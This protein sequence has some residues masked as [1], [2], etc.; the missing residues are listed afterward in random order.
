LFKHF[1]TEFHANWQWFDLLTESRAVD[2]T[3]GFDAITPILQCI[4][5]PVRN[6]KMSF[7]FE[8]RVG[9]GRLLCCGLNLSQPDSPVTR[10]FKHSLNDY[11]Q[12]ADFNPQVELDVASL[13]GVLQSAP[14][15]WLSTHVKRIE[16]NSQWW[17]SP[18]GNCIDGESSTYWKSGRGQP[19]PHDIIIELDETRVIWGARYT[20]RQDGLSAGWVKDY[21][22]YISEEPSDWGEPTMSGRFADSAD[23]Q[24]MVP[25]LTDDGFNV[26]HSKRGC[27]VKFRILS[28]HDGGTADTGRM[29]GSVA[30]FDLMIEQFRLDRF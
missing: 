14:A 21:E 8:A 4:D 28:S 15:N 3:A 25:K 13:R 29:L 2:L 24:R 1:P 10:Q 5:H 27:F 17:D 6:A 20:P 26:T 12:G 18:V 19:Y 11:I 9:Q 16:A 7:L 22:V 23:S 30:E